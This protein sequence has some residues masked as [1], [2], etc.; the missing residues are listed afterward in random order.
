[1]NNDFQKMLRGEL[2]KFLANQKEKFPDNEILKI[3][4]HC[5]DHNSD[6]PDELIGRIL[7]VPETWLPSKK[8]LETLDRNGCDTFTVTNHNNAR[9][10]YE[11]Q[12]KGYDVL[13]AAE[14]SCMVPDFGIGIH[15][16]AYGFTPEQ[17]VKLEKLRRNIYHFQEYSRAN[18]IPTI[19][20]H[21]LYHYS[22]KQNPP[23][24][25]FNKML[26]IFERFE[27]LNGQRDT[28]QNLL[29]KEWIE[30]STRENI[31]KYAAKFGIN[32]SNF[33]SDPYRKTMSGGS[34]CH[35]GIFAGM[36][37]TYLYVPQLE[38]R[39]KN[40]S[41]SQ[42]ALEA[43]R[44]GNMAPY[45]KYQN[46]EKMTISFLNYA[47]QIALNYKDPGLV[48]LVLHKGNVT[49]KIISLAASNLF[50]EVQ[51]HRTTTSF[52]QIFHDSMMG[53]KPPIIKKYILKPVY[54]PI[55]NEAMNLAITQQN[56]NTTLVDDFYNSIFLINNQLY[57][58]LAKRLDKKLS[59]F[60]E[61]KYFDN[62]NLNTFID[63]LEL[64]ISI[65]SYIDKH[66]KKG[67]KGIDISG[68][69]DDLSFP[70]FGSLFILSAHFISAKTLYNTRPLLRE[71]SN[72]LGK[73]NHSERI[74]WLTDT[75]EDS[76]DIS[77][78][79]KLMHSEIKKRNLPIDI[80][81]CNS[82]LKSDDNLIVLKPV[83]EFPLPL[84]NDFLLRI[85]NFVELHN[86]FVAG[87][88]DR[89]ICSTEGVMG[90]FGLYL[91]HAYTAEAMFFMHTDLLMFARKVLNIEGHNLNRVL[92]ILRSFYKAFDKVLVLNSD[93]KEWLSGHQM[94]L[95]PDKIYQTALWVNQ[96]FLPNNPDTIITDFMKSVGI[97]L[98]T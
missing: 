33:C 55:F 79:L 62:Q 80:V 38:Q 59:K 9:S 64:P 26:L 4:L 19:W 54:K 75:F 18:N 72:N 78:F 46:A 67:K 68:F 10:C 22:K 76:N 58:I 85:P 88:Y 71:F 84:Y 63:K 34:D 53:K 21:P 47:C 8:L 94:N 43:I 27:V 36:T 66:D 29:V 16:L 12:D 23:Q 56:N 74:L 17:E 98:Q 65:R 30:Q 39:L 61:Q 44:Q 7:N 24:D 31:D 15:V 35:M 45:G 5:H 37:G 28:W 49:D 51:K 89:I 95:K 97:N 40:E 11:L 6:V 48:R 32:P 60:E 13:S 86:L 73:F 92:R 96:E 41:R 3:D 90:L 70:F 1:M 50:C 20:A 82:N 81:T 87:G 69:L 25:F 93:Q 83:K 52:I 2:E 57:N 77:A 14:F 91:K 42:L